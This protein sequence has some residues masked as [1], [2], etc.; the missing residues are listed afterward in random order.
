MKRFVF[1]F[2]TALV[3]QSILAQLPEDALRLSWLTPGGTARS[4]AIGGAM[5]SLG[6]DI[7]SNFVNPAGLAFY[8]TGELV[9]TPQLQFQKDKSAYLNTN[10]SAN[11]PAK[12]A[13]GASG[14]VI[15]FG[16]GQN[17]NTFSIAINRAANFNSH[18]YYQGQN[19]SS[20]FSEQYAEEFSASG[21]GIN[22]AISSP[23]ISYGTRMALYTY[24]IDT[25]TIAGVPQ[26]IG[27]PQ[28]A[29]IVN[30]FNDLQT[31]GG[32]TEVA[33][34]VAG[35]KNDKFYF[36]GSLGVPIM[37]Y[38]RSQTYTESDASGNTNN[39]FDFSTYHEQYDSKGFGVNL[40]LGMIYRPAS[41][42]R[43]GI[44]VHTPTWYAITD[45][46][47]ASMVTNTENY[48]L[49]QK[50]PELSIN[51]TTLDDSTSTYPGSVKYDMTSPWR[52][53]ISGSYVFRE[54]EDVTQQRG[55]VTADIEYITNNT[56]RFSSYDGESGN[57][58]YFD[59]V[60]NT[61]KNYYK[62]AFNFR[63]GGELK[64]NTIAARAGMAYYMNPYRQGDLKADRFLVSAGLAYRNK[65]I[66]VDLTYVQNFTKDVNYPYRLA[67]KDNVYASV[68]QSS[69]TVVL[70]VGFKFQ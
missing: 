60:N 1:I 63:L 26:V 45:N 40:K 16:S 12:F 31:S 65:G 27:Q 51:S 19:N 67:Q 69:G 70:T 20:S 14:L 33:I 44:A 48:E 10:S 43:V 35:N 7:T 24:L 3:H 58:A 62:S 29:G 32:I 50:P 15:G 39:D 41:F 17:T 6:G 56:S 28:K 55:F 21:M 22:D 8:K 2:A 5:G 11:A 64:F 53:I 9:L 57:T 25:A 59:A 49:S 42:W 68:K 66:F 23:N 37:N 46:L 38:S 47:T 34:S 52:F 61:I 4:Q 13:I 30:Q 18:T 54:V 36:G